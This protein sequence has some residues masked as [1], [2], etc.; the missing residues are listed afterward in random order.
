[1]S[2]PEIAEVALFTDR[3]DEAKRFY[4]A[5][6]ERQADS[7]W[8]GGA[9]YSSGRLT[10]LVHERGAA[11]EGGPPNVDHVAFAVDDL[12]EACGRLRAQGVDVEVDPRQFPWGRSAYVRDPDG[13]LV[14]LAER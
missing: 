7:E 9:A 14:E 13:R 10:L 4:A 1:V 5:L 2:R 3:P 8:P 6:L 12:E 11:L